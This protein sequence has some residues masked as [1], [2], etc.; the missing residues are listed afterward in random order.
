MKNVI[1]NQKKFKNKKSDHRHKYKVI[2]IQDEETSR[3]FLAHVC[4]ICNKI[5]TKFF[6]REIKSFQSLYP[7]LSYVAF[8]FINLSDVREK[9]I[10]IQQFK[11]L[12]KFYRCK[13]N[14]LD[15]EKYFVL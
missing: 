4:T 5:R 3:L 10:I 14:P 13:Y 8:G 2:L 11:G 9:E 7:S 6:Y 1:Y 15:N 12:D